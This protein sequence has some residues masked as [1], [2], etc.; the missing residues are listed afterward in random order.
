MLSKHKNKLRSLQLSIATN[1][2]A[3]KIDNK[4][5]LKTVKALL[6]QKTKLQFRLEDGTK[7]PDH[8]HVTEIGVVSKDFIDCGGRLR[9]SK[10]VNFQLWN[11]TDY[12]H[13]L[14]AS[15]LLDIIEWSEKLLS[16]DVNLD[17]EVEYQR[18]TIGKYGLEY[19][20][21][22]FVLTAK[23][24][25]CLAKDVCIPSTTKQNLNLSNLIANN[26]CSNDSGCC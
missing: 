20:G 6:L 18:N 12:D 23:T 15:K 7:V 21:T 4:M 24:T 16:V 3:H 1:C 22:S 2:Q 14:E 5:N 13:R 11:D 17:I 25:D 19:D 8:F 9:S 10:V 26:N